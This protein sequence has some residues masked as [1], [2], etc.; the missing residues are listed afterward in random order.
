MFLEFEILSPTCTWNGLPLRKAL[1]MFVSWEGT[2]AWMSLNVRPS[3][4]TLSKTFSMSRSAVLYILL[5]LSMK[6]SMTLI[7]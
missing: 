1:K 7:S 4:E 3:C 6:L 2:P 5:K